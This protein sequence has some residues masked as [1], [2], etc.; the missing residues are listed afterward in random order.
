MRVLIVNNIPAPYFDPLFAQLGAE[1]DWDLTVCYT[2]TWNASAGWIER[3]IDE[4]APHRTVILDRQAPDLVQL[5][6]STWAAGVALWREFRQVRP[7]YVISYGYTLAPQFIAIL[8]SVLTQTPFAVIGD[9]NIH[10]DLATGWRRSLK[11]FWL[12]WIVNRAAALIYIG[13][14]NRMFWE[15]YGAPP[16]RLFAARYA[17]DNE[18]FER[19]ARCERDEAEELL[20]R[21]DFAGKTVFLFVGRLVARKNV[22]L[23]VRAMRGISEEQVA[24]VIAGDGEERPKLEALAAGDARIIFAGAIAQSELPRYYTLA[25]A[26]LLPARDEPWGLVVN[27]AMAIGLAVIAHRQVGAA[28]D[29]VDERNGVALETFTVEEVAAAM[30]HLARDRDG[31]KR[32]Q[33]NSRLKIGEWSI[34]GAARGI[35]EAVAH[36][37]T[38]GIEPKRAA[39]VGD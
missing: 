16:A 25:D 15:R 23:L 14:A 7:D 28:V 18:H 31:L 26:L 17:V 34:S 38:R 1:P 3:E 30:R 13:T 39:A 20:R 11:N 8:W 29:L 4:R 35:R 5:I 27:E 2:S 22:D 19:A 12:R 6:G 33:E 37:A 21:W 32:M 36:T 24:L 9:A 10:A